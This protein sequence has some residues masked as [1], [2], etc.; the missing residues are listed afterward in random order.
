MADYNIARAT[1]GGD[2]DNYEV[3]TMQTDSATGQNETEW[4]NTRASEYLGYYKKIPELK[5]AINAHAT[6]IV[7]QGYA[8]KSK[9]V[10]DRITGWGED[11][12][13]S[14]IWKMM[15]EKKVYGD[16]FCEI[17][18]NDKGS[19]IN[20]KSLDPAKVKIVVDKRGRIKRYEL[21]NQIGEQKLVQ[22]FR[23]DEILHLCNDRIADEIHGVSMIEAV[24]WIILAKNEAMQDRKEL[25]HRN[26]KP[27]VVFK[28]NTDDQT[29]IDKFIS[30]M[31]ACLEKG[32]NIYIPKGEV[33]WDILSVPAGA[34]LN[35]D[36][37][38]RDLDD[39]FYLTLGIPKA[40][41]GGALAA[42]E[43]ASKTSILAY[44]QFWK[45][46]QTELIADIWNQLGIRIEINKSVSI[47]GNLAADEGK[48][49][50]S[51]VVKPNEMSPTMQQE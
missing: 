31:D 23:P 26:V 45:R 15:V 1:E 37:T 35:P 34:T 33:E 24:E 11:T 51:G 19:L 49:I 9:L 41:L 30:K 21:I 8:S 29:K 10:L 42:T 28:L 5:S 14:I 16:A 32:R 18:R 40:A 13:N 44:E 46:E 17:I 43:A 4:M 3:E 38:I 20:L 2:P 25:M 48:D 22:K 27:L 50:T 39:T 47:Q 36:P 7:G 6:W 12:F